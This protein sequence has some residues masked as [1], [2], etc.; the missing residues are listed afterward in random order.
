MAN[1]DEM[2]MLTDAFIEYR[3]MLVPVQESI[4]SMVETYD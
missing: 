2:K 1:I 4:K 3:D